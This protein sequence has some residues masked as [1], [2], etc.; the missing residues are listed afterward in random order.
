MT[1][2][3][4]VVEVP[5]IEAKPSLNKKT[6]KRDEGSEIKESQESQLNRFMA[7]IGVS[8]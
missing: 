3:W 8:C 5:L 2:S 4:E 1:H 7:Y 6:E